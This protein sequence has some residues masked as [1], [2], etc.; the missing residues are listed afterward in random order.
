VH[1]M[2]MLGAFGALRV[3]VP[4]TTGAVPAALDALAARRAHYLAKRAEAA[5]AGLDVVEEA[6]GG[7]PAANGHG[8]RPRPQKP[9]ALGHADTVVVRLSATG[10]DA[11]PVAVQLLCQDA[12]FPAL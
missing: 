8:G 10:D 1:T 5:A 4:L 12:E 3:E 9:L 11:A 7:A 2:D 6:N